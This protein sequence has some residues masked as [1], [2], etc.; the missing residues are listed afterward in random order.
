MLK[1]I[2]RDLIYAGHSLAKA[3]SFTSVCV[4]TLGI[5]MAPVIAI[6]YGARLLTMTPPLVKADGLAEVLTTRVGPRGA[7][8]KWSYPDYIDLGSADTGM[9]LTGW[10][11]GKATVQTPAGKTDSPV[12]FVS[13]NYFKTFGVPL[14][15]GA[16][17]DEPQ[18]KRDSAQPQESIDDP[19]K[20]E[21]VVILAHAFWKNR[22]GSDPDI[23]GKTLTLDGVPHTVVGI[24]AELFEG[25][26]AFQEA[27]LFV[28]LERYPVLLEEKNA[29]YD[30]GNEWVHI[31]G[32]L[33]PGISVAQASAA[34]STVTSQLA[35]QYAKT[36]ENKA[37]I[38]RTYQGVGN[39]ISSQFTLIKAVGFTLTGAVLL[40]VCLNISGM[41]QVRVAMRERELSIRQ[42]IGASRGRLVQ[43]L[44]AESMLLAGLGGTLASL[45][46]FNIPSALSWM[47]GKPIPTQFQNLLRVDLSMI[48]FCF[49]LCLSASL[50]FGFLPAARFSRPVIISSLKDEAG[51]GGFRVGRVHRVTAA[52]QVAI[53]VPLLVM[54]GICLDRV[55]A[56][57]TSDLGFAS[58]LLYA[59][60]LPIKAGSPED[61][62]FQIRTAQETLAKANGVGA[63]TVADGLPLDFRYRIQRVA[64]QTEANV[65]PRFVSVHV[66]RV[67]DGYLNTMS[68]PLWRG[69]DFSAD[70]RAGAELVT[71]ISKALA[72]VLFPD[73][74][75]AA[76]IGKKLTFGAPGVDKTQ[77]TL[78]IV[79]IT[80]DFPTSQMS[81]ER[82]QLLLPLA[83]HSDV[84]RNSVT[85][86]ADSGDAPTLM[87]IGRSAPG[88]QAAK[89]T[90][91]LEN[92]IRERDR[93][94]KASSVVT[95]MWLRKN[96]MNDFLTQS[97]VAGM[98]GG[99]ILVLAALGIY[100]VVG[101][102]VATRKREIAVRVALGASRAR[103]I[104]MILL[105]VVKSVTPGVFVGMIL[106]A[107]LIRLNGENMGIPLSYVENLA[108]IAGA[109][110]AVIVAVVASFAPARRAAS[111][112]PMVAMR[113]E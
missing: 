62:A 11:T 97:T 81:T 85:V 78:T 4:V 68:I 83:Q 20:T 82:E 38:A 2:W 65:A 80:G 90:G 18:R 26:L 99:V 69:R 13:S 102:M 66:T 10:A 75:A 94:F 76:A 44:L 88:Q 54:G 64:L 67:G 113:S 61:T 86:V 112:Q 34:V 103:V 57:A 33:S 36:N 22:L 45:V 32:R 52:L 27:D 55:R 21:P 5:G 105:D 30:R 8:D 106:T 14:A 92:V 39:L 7:T 74:D 89:L 31:H 70:D 56:T 35:K 19:T 72:E 16:G 50:V 53:A 6:P 77:Q 110:I 63:V 111:V 47:L 1:G 15:R 71:V 12:L 23:L 109:A 9:T 25:H 28:P 95:G 79:G 24:G 41:M 51:G 42:A 49:G 101:L 60:P 17:F 48:A 40:V 96:S 98:A 108:Y 59:A 100:G 46:L 91:A 104:R 3:R 73:A 43:Y 58:D 93:E 29:R 87:L 37:G 84:K 107:A